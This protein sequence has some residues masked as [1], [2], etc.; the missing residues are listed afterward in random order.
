MLVETRPGPRALCP[1]FPRGGGVSVASKEIPAWTRSV[2]FA[3]EMLQL[4]GPFIAHQL[5]NLPHLAQGSASPGGQRGRASLL[6][7]DPDVG[8]S[9]ELALM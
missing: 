1:L 5:A 6:L 4:W 3:C 9:P 7:L 8:L 2:W